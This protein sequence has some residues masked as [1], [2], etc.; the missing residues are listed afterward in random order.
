MK[1]GIAG[2]NTRPLMRA[3]DPMIGIAGNWGSPRLPHVTDP[4]CGG[5]VDTKREDV[6]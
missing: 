2:V 5:E 3:A 4:R 6:R 1:L